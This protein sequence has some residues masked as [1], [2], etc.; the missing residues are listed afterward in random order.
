M[1]VPPRQAP[2]SGSNPGAREDVN[3]LAPPSRV[4]KMVIDAVDEPS[5]VVTAAR[6][7]V[8]DAHVKTGGPSLARL[9]CL[10][11]WAIQVEPPSSV[12][13]IVRS[14]ERSEPKS[15]HDTG[16]V[17]ASALSGTKPSGSVACCQVLP[18]S[19]VTST[20]LA[21]ESRA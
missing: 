8:A 18:P 4:A 13:S 12:V 11:R 7:D 14:S 9:L 17:Q 6:H 21:T 16:S 2:P 1:H 3:H 10:T 15:E 19:L 20:C 5:K